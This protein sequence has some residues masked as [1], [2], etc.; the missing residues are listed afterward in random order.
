MKIAISEIKLIKFRCYDCSA[1]VEW[2]LEDFGNRVQ[3]A[4][5]ENLKRNDDGILITCP[6]CGEARLKK[7]GRV[8]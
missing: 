3:D 4:V 2:E 5:D 7:L 8:A 1:A 6:R